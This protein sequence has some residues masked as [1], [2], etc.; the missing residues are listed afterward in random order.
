VRKPK[1]MYDTKRRKT[2]R[3]QTFN[4]TS[5]NQNDNTFS[6]PSSALLRSNTRQLCAQ[7]STHVRSP[8]GKHYTPTINR[9]L[10][11]TL[12]TPTYSTH[13]H[14]SKHA[15]CHVP[16]SHSSR[17]LYQPEYVQWVTLLHKLESPLKLMEERLQFLIP[18]VF[19]NIK[20]HF[21]HR[22]LRILNFGRNY[23]RNSRK[24]R[25]T[26]SPYILGQDWPWKKIPEKHVN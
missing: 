3:K 11:L 4:Q 15:A 22:E 1:I 13:S 10:T 12:H 8:C 23:R 16:H 14:T 26:I 6:T 17:I 24:T 21:Y 20:L 19:L 5:P 18:K 2:K 7:R 25:T 9:R